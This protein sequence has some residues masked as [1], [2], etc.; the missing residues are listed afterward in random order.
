[1]GGD[2]HRE[3]VVS[4]G[5]R[6]R[7]LTEEQVVRAQ[8][9]AGNRNMIRAFARVERRLHGGG[10]GV[11]VD[12]IVAPR[13]EH[14]QVLDPVVVLRRQDVGV[15][16]PVA[17]RSR[18]KAEQFGRGTGLRIAERSVVE[19]EVRIDSDRRGRCRQRRI[20]RGVDIDRVH[21]TRRDGVVL[22]GQQDIAQNPRQGPVERAIEIG[23]LVPDRDRVPGAIAGDVVAGPGL[24]RQ[25]V[26]R[27]RSRRSFE[28]ERLEIG[29]VDRRRCDVGQLGARQRGQASGSVVGV[30]QVRAV[31]AGSTVDVDDP[32]QR[33]HVRRAGGIQRPA[34]VVEGVDA[35]LAEQGRSNCIRRVQFEAF[36]RVIIGDKRGRRHV[37]CQV[38][39]Q[40]QRR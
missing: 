22:A 25:D 27:V 4:L 32:I 3:L 16:V 6:P 17:D 21:R 12:D 38:T 23:R 33:L 19:D 29:V 24:S 15:G 34:I 11:D 30:G 37:R 36:G 7:A 10:C 2:I 9:V 40:L 31:G 35:V 8:P 20:P 1:M 14:V 28:E 39:E 5:D 13:T 18:G 26:D